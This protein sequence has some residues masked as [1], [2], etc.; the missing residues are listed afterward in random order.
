M[1]IEFL[2]GY[3]YDT[4]NNDQLDPSSSSIVMDNMCNTYNDSSGSSNY[5]GNS[6]HNR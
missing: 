1:N 6:S 4:V 3:H 5:N 2:V